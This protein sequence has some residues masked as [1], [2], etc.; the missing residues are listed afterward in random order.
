[1]NT[2]TVTAQNCTL[3]EIDAELEAAFDQMQ[4]EQVPLIGYD[5]VSDNFQQNETL[6]GAMRNGRKDRG[7]AP[8]PAPGG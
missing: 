3:F 4:E 1:M 7:G 8:A 6:H 5:L 2:K